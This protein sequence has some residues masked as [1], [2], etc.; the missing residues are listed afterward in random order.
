MK[1][2]I[3][4]NIS[5]HIFLKELAEK[6]FKFIFFWHWSGSMR[7]Y[8]IFIQTN[9]YFMKI[10]VWPKGVA[11]FFQQA[12]QKK[13]LNVIQHQIF[14]FNFIFLLNDF[15]NMKLEVLLLHSTTTVV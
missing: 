5:F 7:R 11:H 14:S 4:N 1:N 10:E 13:I 3:L 15:S 2:K 9:K 8:T 6:V 12:F